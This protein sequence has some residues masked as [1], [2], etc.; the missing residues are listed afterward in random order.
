MLIDESTTPWLGWLVLLVS[1]LGLVV[2]IGLL[3]YNLK[4]KRQLHEQAATL[5]QHRQQ[6]HLLTSNMS[7]WIWTVDAKNYFTYVSPSVKKLLG[8][9]I[10]DLLGH[11]VDVIAHPSDREYSRA[12]LEH[13]IHSGHQGELVPY[14]DAIARFA[15]AHKDGHLVWTEAAVRLFFTVDGD[16]AGAQGCSRDIGE[17]KQAEEA[18]RQMAFNDPLTQ[19]PN[20]RLLNDRIQQTISTCK[21]SKEYTALLFLDIDNFKY[22]NDN[23]GHDNGDLLLQQI[24]RRIATGVRD[25]DTL[26]RFGGDEFVIVSEQLSPDLDLARQQA[27]LIGN[28]TMELFERE[29]ILQDAIC[30]VSTSIGIVLFNDDERSVTTLLKQADV[31]MYQAKAGGRNRWVISDT[32]NPITR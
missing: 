27:A 10:E 13:L 18:V 4:L 6:V 19:L 26:A 7:D 12:Q 24:A 1:G 5:Q 29:F 11:Y 2:I 16:Y 32:H 25:S 15:L 20:R 23:Y 22:I 31:A 28:K 21:R 14:R 3:V 30:H 8:Y 17:R 9:D